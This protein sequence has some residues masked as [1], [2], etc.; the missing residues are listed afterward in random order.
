M[1]LNWI[2]QSKTRIVNRGE[3]AELQLDPLEG[4][5]SDI[6]AVRIP[7]SETTYYLIENRQPIGFDKYLPGSGVL[8]MYADDKIAECRHGEAPVKLIDADPGI[9]NLAGAAFDVDKKDSFVDS[10]NGLEIQLME[11]IGDSYKISIV[12]SKN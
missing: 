10:E 1:R 12:W 11:K 6:L 3:E 8:I 5:A 7:L 2:D 4:S 9:P